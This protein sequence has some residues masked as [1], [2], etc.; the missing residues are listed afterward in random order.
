MFVLGGD[1]QKSIAPISRLLL[2]QQRTLLRSLPMY[3]KCP[4]ADFRMFG[5][6]IELFWLALSSLT[7]LLDVR[8][9]PL[10]CRRT[11][12]PGR[13]AGTAAN[14][15]APGYKSNAPKGYILLQGT[16]L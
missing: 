7:G 2:P 16:K 1:L 5:M 12:S 14:M 13:R 15:L 8:Q 4:I 10:F 11:A 9:H 6:A 3:E